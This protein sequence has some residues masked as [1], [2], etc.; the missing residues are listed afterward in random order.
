MMWLALHAPCRL[1][2]SEPQW[3]APTD[4]PAAV[5]LTDSDGAALPLQSVTLAGQTQA[6]AG[7]AQATVSLTNGWLRVTAVLPDGRIV[8]VGRLVITRGAA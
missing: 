6:P 5:W 3:G 4:T 8:H 2:C 1:N 7:A